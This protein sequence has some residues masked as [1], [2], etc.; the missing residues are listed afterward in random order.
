MPINSLRMTLSQLSVTVLRWRRS[1]YDESVHPAALTVSPM[2]QLS[3]Q[4]P[5]W[6][7]FSLGSWGWCPV[8]A[9]LLTWEV[10]CKHCFWGPVGAGCMMWCPL[11][12]SPG[13]GGNGGCCS[14]AT[15]TCGSVVPASSCNHVPAA[16]REQGELL[17]GDSSNLLWSWHRQGHRGS[18]V[19]R[20]MGSEEGDISSLECRCWQ[21]WAGQ[22]LLLFCCLAP[23][24]ASGRG[25][26]APCR[27]LL[28]SQAN[29]SSPCK[30]SLREAVM[31]PASRA[32]PHCRD[33]GCTS[34]GWKWSQCQWC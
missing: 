17:A 34:L 1:Q 12:L 16:S 11:Y 31:Q 23:A 13:L 18:G 7:S 10:L 15:A 29:L 14:S 4:L 21:E 5:G 26:L 20:S 8:L 30:G 9:W 33:R 25:I 22:I 19:V 6:D 24:P 27:V 32:C 3:T 28:R 2:A